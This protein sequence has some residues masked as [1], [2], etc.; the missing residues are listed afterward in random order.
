MDLAD[1]LVKYSQIHVLIICAQTVLHVIQ[2][3]RQHTDVLVPMDT[4]VNIVQ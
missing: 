2:F 3:Q 1:Q 4:Q